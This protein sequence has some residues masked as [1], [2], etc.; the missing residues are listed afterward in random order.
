MLPTHFTPKVCDRA[1]LPLVDTNKK[2]LLSGRMPSWFAMSIIL[3][4]S[5]EE[6]YVHTP[7]IGYI[8]IED[9]KSYK[10]GE[11]ISVP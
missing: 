9:R 7:G 4:Y 3:S 1:F 5:N 11:I 2:L 10:H 8:K 6:K